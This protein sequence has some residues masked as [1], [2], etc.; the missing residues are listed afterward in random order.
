MNFTDRI[1]LAWLGLSRRPVRTGLTSLG[2]AVAV[3]SMVIFLSLG[4]GLRQTFVNELKSVGPDIQVS[5]AESTQGLLLLPP[6]D[7]SPETTG[8]IEKLAS[9]LGIVQITPV[10][11]SLKQALDPVDSAVYYG[12][13]A[14]Q[15][16]HALFPGVRVA[17]GR[18]LQVGDANSEVA[19][20]GAKAARNLKVQVGDTVVL[21]RRASV[22]VIGILAPESSLTDTFTFLPLP[23]VQ[24][25]FNLGD[26][27][28]MV[29]L[30]LD[31]PERAHQV[32]AA[33]TGRLHLAAS[34]RSD[35][36]RFVDRMLNS[37]DVISF[38][39]SVIALV[40]GGV[41]VVNTV[42]MG[43]QERTQEFGTLRAIG[44]RPATIQGLVLMESLLLSLVGGALGLLLGWFGM[45]G[46]NVYTEHLAGIAGSAL[47]LRLVLLTL[48]V[49]LLL[50]V[51]A[52]AFP[53]R[54]ASRT[55]INAALGRA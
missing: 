42:M 9:A 12:L 18:L 52:G 17:Q 7:L 6:P 26:R 32:A 1:R 54:N 43:V 31:R 46:I 39:L 15:G 27:I 19:V 44:A 11:V 49:S 23:A 25:A 30:R 33:L 22:R 4:E 13:P 34:T 38:G 51:F 36:F 48:V 50:G 16:I 14:D 29:A 24:A 5:R 40:V 41:A 3:S 55:T 10:A 21:N 28:S 8:A 20:L 53:A 37:V 47:T 35:L 2:I 45:L